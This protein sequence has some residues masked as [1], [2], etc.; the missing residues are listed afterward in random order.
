MLTIMLEME[1]I[2]V[3]YFLP[4]GVAH[5][6]DYDAEELFAWIEKICKG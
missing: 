1:H 2:E 3:D 5:A 4:W 6:G